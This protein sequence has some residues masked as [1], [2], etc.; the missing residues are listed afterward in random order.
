MGI[1]GFFPGFSG[2]ANPSLG[3]DGD[4]GEITKPPGGKNGGSPGK[5][6]KF[7]DLEGKSI[8]IDTS[9]ECSKSSNGTI[10]IGL[11]TKLLKA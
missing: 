11:N 6:S 10:Q 5:V 4:L 1:A 7:R 2:L 9:R 3:G 8:I